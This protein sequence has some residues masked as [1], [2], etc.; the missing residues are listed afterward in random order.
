MKNVF[1]CLTLFLA[2]FACSSN[3]DPSSADINAFY[4]TMTNLTVQVAYEPDAEPY[5]GTTGTGM[6]YWDFL[7]ANLQALFEGRPVDVFTD[8]P[9]TLE[10][11]EAIPAQ[12]KTEWTVD[13]ILALADL[14]RAIPP[15]DIV[16]VFFVVFLNGYLVEDGVPNQNVIGVSISGTTVIAIF[17]DVV[18]S[19][20]STGPVPKFVEQSTL[21]HE[22]GHA[23]GLVNNGVPMVTPH[24]DT[25]HGA[26][27]N[28]PDCVM[29]WANEGVADLRD[30]VQNFILT[31]STVMIGDE[32]LTDT[33]SYFP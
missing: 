32:C 8:V 25:D 1:T 11:M 29:Y 21:I 27:C 14:Y 31:G 9:K 18:K 13:E 12:G 5:I 15:S 24:Q 22:M 30:F 20:G 17:K 7:E 26:H 6:N 23:L 16:G 2:F 4:S 33:R 10:E 28:N 3:D 19:T